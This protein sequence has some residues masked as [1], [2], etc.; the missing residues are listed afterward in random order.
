MYGYC[1]FGGITNIALPVTFGAR[2]CSESYIMWR[3]VLLV[4]K[5]WLK[6]QYISD[7]KIPIYDQLL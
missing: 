5:S 6:W 2:D 3:G 1:C 4:R 7:A